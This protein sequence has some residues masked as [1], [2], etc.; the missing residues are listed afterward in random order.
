MVTQRGLTTLNREDGPWAH[1]KLLVKRTMLT[2]G[3]QIWSLGWEDPLGKDMA[4]HYSTLAWKISWTEEP[5]GPQ[6]MGSQSIGHSWAPE[7][8]H[9]I[10]IF[11]CHSQ[12][13]LKDFQ[14]AKIIPPRI[15]NQIANWLDKPIKFSM[16]Y[17]QLRLFPYRPGLLH[18]R[19]PT[20]SS[21]GKSESNLTQSCQVFS[22]W[23]LP[24]ECLSKS[25]ILGEIEG[26]KKRGHQ[27]MLMAGWHHWCNE[28][29]L[30]QTQGDDAGQE[31][32][33]AA[34]H[35]VTESWTWLG[36]WTT[37]TFQIS[38]LFSIFS[39][40]TIIKTMFINHFYH[41]IAWEL[42]TSKRLCPAQCSKNRDPW[43]ETTPPVLQAPRSPW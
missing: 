40:T 11:M 13:H 31:A 43:L 21:R 25:L 3:T 22:Y 28:H 10:L 8:T 17:T 9:T 29:E 4:I 36:N 37:T 1:E 18:Y 41:C 26:R 2:Q 6:T 32:W 15:Q 23:F 24:S 39:I 27:R 20:C 16:F 34:V 12:I 30:G 14:K 35:G 33:H 42:L 7:Y 38:S 5:G 19:Y